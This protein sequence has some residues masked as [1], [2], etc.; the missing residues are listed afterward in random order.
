MKIAHWLLVASSVGLAACSQTPEPT[1]SA[2]APT[3]PAAIA[4][5]RVAPSDLKPSRLF[6]RKPLAIDPQLVS[7]SM[8]V[9][10]NDT[11]IPDDG[12]V[13]HSS[14]SAALHTIP[15]GTT[16]IVSIPI[17]YT[18]GESHLYLHPQ[19]ADIQAALAA[20]EVYDADGVR[21]NERAPRAV[22]NGPD[23]VAPP[24]SAIP[25]AG[26]RPGIFTVK[27]GP[28]AR[29]AAV[30]VDVGMAG[31]P[32][33]M[34]LKPQT[35][36]HL[37]G[38]DQTVDAE[39]WDNGAPVTGARLTGSLVKPD[40]T[41]GAKLSFFEVGGGVYRAIVDTAM[42]LDDPTGAYRVAVRA[43]GTNGSGVAF[44]RHGQ[45]GFHFGVPTGRIANVGATRTVTDGSGRIS[46][47]EVDVTI[48]SSALDRLELQGALATRGLDGREHLVASSVVAAGYDVGQH[49]L[50]LRFDA[51][52]VQLTRLEGDLV[53]RNV[54]LFSLGTN[55]LFHRTV[56]H[57]H[58]F[59][60]VQRSQLVPLAKLTPQVQGMIH[61]GILHQD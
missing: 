61:D 55:T 45:T 13:T 40:G 23:H 56:F 14:H 44:A 2:P 29:G 39:L 53:L 18:D 41:P 5:P 58:T 16:S 48:E 35:G 47:F 28:A 24:M 8:P 11:I 57:T 54:R 21:I 60:A 34:K 31:S 19:G 42:T 37:F 17:D 1:P 15:A 38:N 36:Q 52:H 59:P 7:A 50:T 20:I 43:E 30:V 46:A 3:A 33:V 4:Q 27:V 12:V 25:L 26:H 32:L 6:A 10:P 49:T 22:A 9:S 51:G